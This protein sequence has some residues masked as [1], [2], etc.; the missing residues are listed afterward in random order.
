MQI[1]Q[2]LFAGD[3]A[4]V[5]DSEEKLRE[6]VVEC[7]R[8]CE[9][10]K[11]RVNVGRNQVMMCTRDGGTGGMNVMLNGKMLEEVE[12]FKYLGSKVAVDEASE[13]EV[14]HRVNE[15]CKVLGACKM[16]MGC[17]S[18]GMDAKRAFYEGVIVP[19]VLYGSETWGLREAER[20]KLNV[21]EMK[22][23]RNMV[24][25]KHR[26]R[27]RNEE[28]R[29]RKVERREL[30]ERVDGRVLRWFGHMERMNDERVVRKTMNYQVEG[31]RPRG[32]PRF[33]WMDGV[34]RALNEKGFTV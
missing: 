14:Y 2:L 16:V 17:R 4:L 12:E 32:R 5:A 23:L 3:T 29:R 13:V 11:L 9:R 1:Y 20:R 15:M 27:V 6:R 30:A 10:R 7:G 25:V 19:T 22:Y 8:V 24:G 21:F 31:E 26:D 18:L 34:K 33:R 28:V